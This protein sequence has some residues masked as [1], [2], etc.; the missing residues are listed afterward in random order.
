MS[1][2]SGVD[3][4]TGSCN[5]IPLEPKLVRANGRKRTEALVR[6]IVKNVRFEL[7]E[8]ECAI[9]LLGPE[10]GYHKLDADLPG[11]LNRFPQPMRLKD[12]QSYRS[13][14]GSFDLCFED[15]WT[16]FFIAQ[17][18]ERSRHNRDL[19][20]IHLDDH[21]D[22]MPT[23]LARSGNSLINP[24]SGTLFDPAVCEHWGTAICSGCVS[25][26]NFITPFFFSGRQVHVR[27]INNETTGVG[28]PQSVIQQSCR[29]PLIP[30]YEFASIVRSDPSGPAGSGTYL[31]GASPDHVL[32]QLPAG[33]TIVHMDLDYFI[34]DF[35]GNAAPEKYFPSPDL[36]TQGLKKMDCFFETLGALG[37]KIE[38]WMVATSPGFCSAQH[39]DWLLKRI[40][41]KIR[42]FQAL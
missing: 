13:R 9:R 5:L 39:W 29:Y 6:E 38:R 4:R 26:G 37:L 3:A 10:T 31:G 19:I 34:N 8:Q 14:M 12:L 21:A 35:N 41:R 1:S 20:L 15:C 42:E 40:E 2:K 23:L 36:V 18:F 30:D 24:A 33:Q 22:M 25:I 28:D 32:R 11:V 17:Q 27:H 16:G 7:L